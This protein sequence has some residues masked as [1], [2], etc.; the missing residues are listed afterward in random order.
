MDTVQENCGAWRWRWQP[1]VVFRTLCDRLDAVLV[2][3]RWRAWNG[4]ALRYAGWKNA[5]IKALLISAKKTVAST[6]ATGPATGVLSLIIGENKLRGCCFL[7]GRDVKGLGLP[8]DFLELSGLRIPYQ[9][10]QRG[11]SSFSPSACAA[12]T[13]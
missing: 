5:L 2:G 6:A 3:L 11:G 7:I 9:T 10:G 13:C 1:T 4:T 8:R 12:R